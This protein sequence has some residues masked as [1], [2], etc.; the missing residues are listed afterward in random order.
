MNER[1]QTKQRQMLQAASTLDAERPASPPTPAQR[2]GRR[3]ALRQFAGLGACMALGGALSFGL[4]PGAAARATDVD[5]DAAAEAVLR[6]GGVVVL[7]RHALAP[8][9]F[10]PPEFRIGDCSTQRNLSD[11]GRAQAARFGQWFASRDLRPA[12]VRSSPWCRCVDTAELAFGRQETWVPLSS[13]YRDDEAQRRERQ[14]ALRAAL[15]AHTGAGSGFE[16]WVSHAFVQSALVG[17][18]TGS[19]EALLLRVDEQGWPTVVGLLQV[20]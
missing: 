7:L 19:G 18:S 10:D 2:A 11:A 16:V 5:G 6:A 9:T 8:G 20:A 12:A 4:H 17:R 3:L 1:R 15:Q 13:P 14:R